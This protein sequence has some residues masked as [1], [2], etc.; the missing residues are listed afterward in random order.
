M[1]PWTLLGA[2][3]LLTASTQMLWLTYAPI[4]TGAAAA[5]DTTAG[6]IGWLSA[7]FQALYIL[8]SVPAGR[9]L[10]RHFPVALGVGALGVAVGALVRMA[11]P[12]QFTAQLAGQIL[13][14]LAQPLVLNAVTG[15]STRYFPP[16]DR[17]VV[18]GVSTASLFLGILVA[19]VSGPLL[20][21]AGGLGLVLLAQAVP[22]VVVAA[23]L[24]VGLRLRP[25]AP[26][27]PVP[28][29]QRGVY[30][31]PLMWRL[32]LLLFVGYG[33][34]AGLS[35]WLEPILGVYGITS[36]QSGTL[37]AVMVLASLL[38]S[39]LLAPVVVRRGRSRDMLCGSLLVGAVSLAAIA[40]AHPLPWVGAWLAVCGLFTM[41]TL[42]V[43]LELAE[44]NVPASS[45]GAA[46]GFLMLL[47]N[48]G[49]LVMVLAVQGVLHTAPWPLVVLAAALMLVVP[50]AA[51]LP[52]AFRSARPADVTPR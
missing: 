27:P 42:P 52:A 16:R 34:F 1:T 46:V 10:D 51:R 24:V 3:A 43:V 40:T 44:T 21:E 17:A 12:E 6:G 38:G 29:A 5:L 49:A 11:A 50:L 22:T 31:D 25:P 7:V 30:L 41:S 48:A 13:I 45:Q 32:G 33:V 35:T 36:V 23:A 9:W 2:Y 26:V 8:L 18:V 20:M 37:T 19:M 47:A 14:A 28:E 15:I 4:T 39:A